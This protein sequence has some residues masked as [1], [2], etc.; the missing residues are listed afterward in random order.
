ML[1]CGRNSY[2]V[3][4]SPHIPVGLGVHTAFQVMSKFSL[5]ASGVQDGW[6]RGLEGSRRS[7]EPRV[8]R[9]TRLGRGAGVSASRRTRLSRRGMRLAPTRTAK[10]RQLVEGKNS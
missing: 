3:D 8:R 2:H 5:C 1:P 9:R 7:R 10:G 4:F 6:M